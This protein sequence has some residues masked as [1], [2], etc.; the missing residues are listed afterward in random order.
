MEKNDYIVRDKR[1]L[2]VG[3]GTGATGLAASFLGASMTVLTDLEYTLENLRANVA[4]NYQSLEMSEGSR[5]DIYEKYPIPLVHALD[6][7]NPSTYISCVNTYRNTLTASCEPNSHDCEN[8]CDNNSDEWDVIL[9]ADVVWLEEL[10]EPLVSALR[11]HCTK[12]TM[13][14]LSHQVACYFGSFSQYLICHAS[15]TI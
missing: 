10:V 5:D 13:I 14:Y 2:E 11:A 1:I 3:S 9:G 12:N 6:W 7:S 4:L 15:F 8:S